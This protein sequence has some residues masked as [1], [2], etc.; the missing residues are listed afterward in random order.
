MKNLRSDVNLKVSKYSLEDGL[1]VYFS[2]GS[3]GVPKA[4]LGKNNSL[5]HFIDWEIKTLNLSKTVIVSQLAPVSFDAS[6]RDF[7]V[8][9]FA[10][11]KVSIPENRQKVITTD[12][13]LRWVVDS[14][15]TVLH[16]TPSIFKLIKFRKDQIEKNNKLKYVILAGEKLFPNDVQ[17]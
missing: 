8:P 16:T 5:V 1:Y 17:A 15:V 2:Y 13:L 4:I 6:L 12:G 10:G 9:L 7:F 14:G 3:S 11:G